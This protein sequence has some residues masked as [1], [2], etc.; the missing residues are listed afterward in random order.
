VIAN[1]IAEHT[2]RENDHVLFTD[3]EIGPPTCARVECRC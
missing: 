3:D 2:V 1:A